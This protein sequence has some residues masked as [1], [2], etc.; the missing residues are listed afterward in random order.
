M[1]DQDVTLIGQTNFRSKPKTFGI[2]RVDRRAHIYIIGKTGTGKSTLLETLITQDIQNMDGCV[3]F[4]PHGDL[5]EEVLLRIPEQRKKDLIYLNVP[6]DFEKISFNPLEQV[7]SSKRA[8]F[9]TSLLHAFK[10]IWK[11]SWGVRMEHILRHTLMALMDY[12]GATLAHV[13]RMLNEPDFRKEVVTY[14]ENPEV[15]NF[16]TKEYEDYN[17]RQRSEY[18]API[19]NKVGAFLADPRMHA[20]LTKPRSSFDMKEIM[21]EGKILLID[22]AKGKIGEEA[23]ALLG[24]L[25][26][27]RIE[28]IGLTRA[29]V[30]QSARRDFYVYLDEFHTFTTHALAS[31][32][33]ELRKYRVSMT[34]AHQYL[35]Q[36]DPEI[37]DAILGNA[38]TIICFR[39]GLNDAEILQNEFYPEFKAKD[40]INLPNYHIYLRLMVDGKVTRP[41]SAET[42]YPD[43]LLEDGPDSSVTQIQK[44]ITETILG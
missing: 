10:K 16:W 36:V 38:G 1:N 13:S 27:S 5:I 35:S 37:K 25:I 41:F 44:E 12:P 8:L 15:R 30:P 42:L 2:R 39:I 29:N 19:Q 9:A 23:S 7:D 11:D 6:D 32:L 33:S 14:V 17:S 4:D 22:L 26:L 31:M 40:L 21:D 43:I 24:S 20:I 3:L 18:I 28:L 34:L